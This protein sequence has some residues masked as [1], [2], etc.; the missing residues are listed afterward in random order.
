MFGRVTANIREKWL[1]QAG[2]TESTL[3]E[4]AEESAYIQWGRQESN[5]EPTSECEEDEPEWEW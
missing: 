1:L 2:V 5:E 4:S 3:Q